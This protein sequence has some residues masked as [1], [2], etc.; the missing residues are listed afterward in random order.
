MTCAGPSDVPVGEFAQFQRE[1][2][3]RFQA[4]ITCET[5]TWYWNRLGTLSANAAMWTTLAR[6]HYEAAVLYPLG[7]DVS[8]PPDEFRERIIREQE[9]FFKRQ[10]ER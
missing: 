5:L 2:H 1:V 7:C 9:D 6:H 8:E 3:E 10:G 4:P